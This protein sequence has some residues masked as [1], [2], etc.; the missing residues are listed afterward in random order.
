VDGRKF[1]EDEPYFRYGFEA[2]LLPVRRDKSYDECRDDL[3]NRYPQMYDREP[4]RHG[5]ERGEDYRRALQKRRGA[6]TANT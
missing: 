6:S 4:F 5:Y 1:E 2:A 3:R